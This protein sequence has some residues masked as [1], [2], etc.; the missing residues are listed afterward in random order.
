M[1]GRSVPNDIADGS[2]VRVLMAV[3][4]HQ[5]VADHM[6]RSK[7]HYGAAGLGIIL[8]WSADGFCCTVRSAGTRITSVPRS[9]TFSPALPAAP[10]VVVFLSASASRLRLPLD[11]LLPD[12]AP[13]DGFIPSL[14]VT[15]RSPVFP[16]A[17]APA[18][19]AMFPAV[20][21]RA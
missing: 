4:D 6:K 1:V 20:M 7:R 21:V 13:V 18:I 17:T 3:P 11:A 5:D 9:L 15:G 12:A 8:H 19:S 2:A 10:Y 16:A 14:P